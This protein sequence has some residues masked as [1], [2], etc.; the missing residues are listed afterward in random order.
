MLTPDP[1][2]MKMTLF[3]VAALAAALTIHGPIG[4][5]VSNVLPAS[6]C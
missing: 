4:A 3:T 5:N 2:R 6:H 1:R